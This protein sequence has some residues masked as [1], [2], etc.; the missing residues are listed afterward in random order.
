MKLIFSFIALLLLSPAAHATGRS[1]MLLGLN[2]SKI[3]GSDATHSQNSD[4]L[5]GLMIGSFYE[6]P[7]SEAFSFEPQLRYIEKGGSDS[8]TTNSDIRLRYLEIPLYAKYKIPT[9]T[10]F[11]PYVFAGPALAFRTGATIAGLSGSAVSKLIRGFD[12]GI[13]LG[14]GGEMAVN[15]TVA[16][17]LNAAYGLGLLQTLGDQLEAAASGASLKN[18]GFQL[19][20]GFSFAI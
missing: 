3:H 17:S 7:L 5:T 8:A 2:F 11:T 12:L 18:R 20:A 16:L 13:D 1:G 14:L 4:G 6:L 9:G 19:Y 10:A 15:E